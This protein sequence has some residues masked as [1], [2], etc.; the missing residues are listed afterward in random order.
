[1]DVQLGGTRV[2]RRQ[3]REPVVELVIGR[4]AG[5]RAGNQVGTLDS[6][7]IIRRVVPS[8]SSSRSSRQSCAA[9]IR[10][11]SQVRHWAPPAIVNGAGRRFVGDRLQ[12]AG[13]GAGRIRRCGP[14]WP[15]CEPL[16]TV[17]RAA[18]GLSPAN[19]R[20]RW[21][22]CCFTSSCTAPN[23]ITSPGSSRRDLTRE[24][25]LAIDKR[26]A[27][28]LE[29]SNRQVLARGCDHGVTS[30]HSPRCADFLLRQVEPTP[31]VERSCPRSSRPRRPG[32]PGRAWSRERPPTAIEPRRWCVAPW[33]QADDG[34]WRMVQFH[35]GAESLLTMISS[36]TAKCWIVRCQWAHS[37]A[38]NGAGKAE[39]HRAGSS[40]ASRCSPNVGARL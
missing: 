28:T 34:S 40:K 39:P 19:L 3:P 37:G 32:T 18:A 27:G 4:T 1:M 25:P 38:C 30:R 7:E 21:L 35:R 36:E 24:Q 22:P 8:V 5:S 26:S 2:S 10:K 12:G 29:I 16:L 33:V 13:G 15:G 6:R 14:L 17:G 20:P 9:W 31:A 23:W 11:S